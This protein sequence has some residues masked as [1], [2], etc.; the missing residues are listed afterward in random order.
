MFLKIGGNLPVEEEHSIGGYGN[1]MCVQ[2]LERVKRGYGA[3]FIQLIYLC[4]RLRPSVSHIRA[5]P[6][7]GSWSAGRRDRRCVCV[8]RKGR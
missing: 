3:I 7:R 6:L 5:P 1:P 4:A 8:C 2:D